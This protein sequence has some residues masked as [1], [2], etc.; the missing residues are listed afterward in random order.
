MSRLWLDTE[1]KI[2]LDAQEEL[3]L[4]EDCPCGP[5]VCGCDVYPSTLCLRMYMGGFYETGTG[6][7][8][9]S[10]EIPSNLVN[11]TTLT[12]SEA[13]SA[14]IGELCHCGWHIRYVLQCSGET[15]ILTETILNTEDCDPGDATTNAET[16]VPGDTPTQSANIYRCSTATGTG[17][18]AA[19][20][21][22]FSRQIASGTSSCFNLISGRSYVIREGSC[23]LPQPF[24]FHFSFDRDIDFDI[25]GFTQRIH[26]LSAP[27]VTII[28][29]DGAGLWTGYQVGYPGVSTHFA[30]IFYNGDTLILQDRNAPPNPIP[31][32]VS[33]PTPFRFVYVRDNAFGGTG[34]GTSTDTGTGWMGETNNCELRFRLLSST[35]TVL[36]G[37]RE[38]VLVPHSCEA[39][40]DPCSGGR[41]LVLTATL[42]STCPDL[43]G[44]EVPLFYGNNNFDNSTVGGPYWYTGKLRIGSI[45][46]EV[47][48]NGDPTSGTWPLTITVV[49]Y[50]QP[51]SEHWTLPGFSATGS[52]SLSL[53]AVAST[54]YTCTPLSATYPSTET[55]P[56]AAGWEILMTCID[57]ATCGRL[58]VPPQPPF[59]GVTVSE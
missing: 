12:Y 1:G 49:V 58:D 45:R 59:I 30:A 55:T 36:A 31:N 9:I 7:G 24:T 53:V 18:D 23:S 28:T 39:E 3:T 13:D 48:L 6:T 41:P 16:F 11:A 8:S 37:S 33:P 21:S 20:L 40:I 22:L 25:G 51:G 35:H 46:V 2:I 56:S 27:L 34:T 5:A 19:G 29:W 52:T 10:D 4:C 17:T 50:C 43:D 54:S 15:Y 26:L 14:W 57:D 42:S 44:L 38:I 47:A 32:T